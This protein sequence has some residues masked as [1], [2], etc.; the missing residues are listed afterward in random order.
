MNINVK[1]FNKIQQNWIQQNFS[2]ITDHTWKRFISGMQEWLNIKKSI[3]V[4]YHINRAKGK[5]IIIS[6][7]IEKAFEKSN[8]ISWYPKKSEN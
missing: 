7:D 6:I 4:I 1:I 2:R 5:K 8:T 3:N